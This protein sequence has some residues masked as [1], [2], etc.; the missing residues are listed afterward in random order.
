MS[1][2]L[3]N[4]KLWIK[5][6][7]V[8]LMFIYIQNTFADSIS[9]SV[10]TISNNKQTN[11]IAFG[12]LPPFTSYTLAQQYVKIEYTVDNSNDWAIQVYTH[13][14]QFHSYDGQY[15]G[16][17][18]IT[19]KKRVPLLWQVYTNT[20]NIKCSNDNNWG[21]IKDKK[22]IDWHNR[23]DYRLI[24]YNGLLGKFPKTNR[25]TISPIMLYIG[26]NFTNAAPDDYATQLYIELLPYSELFIPPGITVQQPPDEINII[27]DKIVI[28]A[29]FSDQDIIESATFWYKKHS[30]ANYKKIEYTPYSTSYYFKAEILPNEIT[31]D[32]IEYYFEAKDAQNNI[33]NTKTYVINVIPSKTATIGSSGGTI[34][35]TDGN[36]EDGEAKLSIPGGA[37]NRSQTITMRQIYKQEEIIPGSGIVSGK[38]PVV[39]F[40]FGPSITFEKPVDITLLYF[41]LDND[42]KVELS[43]GKETEIKETELGILWWD[44]FDWRY[45][46]GKIDSQN[47]T[48]SAKVT[49]LSIFGLFPVGYLTKEAFLPKEKIIT[50]NG[51]GINDIVYFGAVGEFEINI[52]D[53][54]GRRI[55]T[56]RDIPEWD[57]RDENGNYVEGGVY[58]YQAEM[59]INGKKEII[60]GAVVVVK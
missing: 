16:L 29:Q 2:M 34:T 6:F 33:T 41:D 35:L 38:M 11:S 57:G 17:I 13:N 52:Y 7:A 45:V 53:M 36:P 3:K 51:D 27:G 21:Y 50:P 22:D 28:Y 54:L 26:G 31:T 23:M 42:G 49:H 56:I 14:T 20:N 30:D 43:N 47:N 58:I 44:G 48:V 55:R 37:I 39:M 9:V 10:F 4:S 46:G 19:K 8:A 1:K 24:A 18:G 32:G 60:S 40:E 15:G 25:P 12:N 5:F 59:M